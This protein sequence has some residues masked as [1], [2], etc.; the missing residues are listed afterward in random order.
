MSKMLT[1]I[2]NYFVS[3]YAALFIL[4][5]NEDP[6]VLERDNISWSVN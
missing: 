1:K 4:L 6:F 3:Y 5:Q 2:F